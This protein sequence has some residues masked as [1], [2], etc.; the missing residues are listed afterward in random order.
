MKYKLRL[1]GI[2]LAC[3]FTHGVL[4]KKDLPQSMSQQPNILWIVTDDQRA[5]SIAAFNMATTGKSESALGYVASPNID[6]LAKGG[7]MF[8]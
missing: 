5:D 4:A 8:T 7:V 1:V 6:A 2:V 3:S